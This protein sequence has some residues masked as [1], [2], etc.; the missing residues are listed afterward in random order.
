M[1]LDRVK[2]ELLRKVVELRSPN[3]AEVGEKNHKIPVV[4]HL[5]HFHLVPVGNEA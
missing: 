1:C 4:P 5:T 3:E 2:R